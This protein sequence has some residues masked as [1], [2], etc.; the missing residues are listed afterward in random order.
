MCWLDLVLA[1]EPSGR[2]SVAEVVAVEVSADISAVLDYYTV[3]TDSVGYVGADCGL[4][5]IHRKELEPSW[6]AV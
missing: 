5:M 1:L 2:V 3:Y 6:V 4:A